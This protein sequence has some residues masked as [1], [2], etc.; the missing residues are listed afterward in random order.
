MRELVYYVAVTLDGFIAG[1]G[2]EFDAFLVEGDHM[3][4]INDRFADTVPTDIAQA[5]GIEQSRST[6]DTVLMGWNTYA[7]GGVPSPY[8]HLDQIVFSRSRAAVADNLRVTAEEP[9][10]VVRDLKAKDG[11]AIWLCG[12]GALAATLADEIDRLVLKRQPL[13][14]GSGIPLFGSRAYRPQRFDLVESTAYTSGVV[15]SEFV[16][17]RAPLA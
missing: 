12:G 1:P 4:A 13:L 3:A 5:L 2:G 10:D 9:V 16:R 8:R 15:V 14:F 7:V 6:F 11:A 17:P